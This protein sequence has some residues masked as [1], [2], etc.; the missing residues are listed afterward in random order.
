M[1]YKKYIK[2]DG[3]LYGPYIYESK[4]IDGKVVSEYHGPKR[5]VNLK[6]FAWISFSVILLIGFAYFLFSFD[7]GNLTGQAVLNTEINYTENQPIKGNI[8]LSLKEGEL[9][10]KDSKLI[11]ENTGQVYE[12]NLNEIVSNS[13]VFGN[14]YVQGVSLSGTGEGYGIEGERQIYPE[15]SFTLEIYSSLNETSSNENINV[16][17][18]NLNE[19]ANV[20]EIELSNETIPATENTETT[21]EPTNATNPEITETTTTTET[22][23]TT[24]TTDA[25]SASPIT[26]FFAR[27]YNFFIALTPTGKVISETN[28]ISGKTSFN[29]PFVYNIL[30]GEGVQLK[31]GSVFVS[32]K[33]IP[34]SSVN[35]KVI[36]N[37]VLV[38]TIYSD[39][40]KGFG[41]EFMGE[42]LE[43]L[44]IDLSSLGLVLNDGELITKIVYGNNE[45]ISTSLVLEQGETV[46]VAENITNSTIFDITVEQPLN[47]ILNDTL[48]DTIDVNFGAN[49]PQIITADNVKFILTEEDKSLLSEEYGEIVVQTTKSEI[50]NGRLIKRYEIGKDWIEYPYDTSLSEAEAEYQ[51]SIDMMKWLKDRAQIIRLKKQAA[52]QPPQPVENTLIE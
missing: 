21:T 38:E 52:K 9:L 42:N 45:I 32:G 24:S 18:Q 23:E 10:P 36:G 50:I 46:I 13:P 16:P 27:I 26:G 37:Q 15:I 49:V 19:S 31:P 11:L 43:I 1:V 28:E 2:R 20:T 33:I 25:T 29:N 40:E 22:T 5:T 44:N 34:D 30:G 6:K 7:F 39:M 35:V 4:R 14:F 17:E 51:M 41:Q 48:N 8:L 12:Y 47:D 3:K